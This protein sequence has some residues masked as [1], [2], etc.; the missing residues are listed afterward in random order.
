MDAFLFQERQY[1]RNWIVW[2]PLLGTDALFIWGL[3]QQLILGKP[4]GD[5][6]MGD[7]GLLGMS[8][9]VFGVT[10]MFVVM[11]LNTEI[12]REGVRIVFFP[13]AKRFIPWQEVER[14]EVRRY[15]PI[16]EF[17]GWGLR[18]RPNGR[19]YSVS[20]RMGL[21]LTLKSGKKVMIGTQEPEEIGRVVKKLL[22]A[23]K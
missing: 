1:F 21:E 18:F 13:M 20:G 17:G 8:A 12:D 11:H 3:Y 19:A 22:P 10:A 16:L 15:N 7:W 6:P 5:N 2:I 9:L 4:W 23:G 14:A